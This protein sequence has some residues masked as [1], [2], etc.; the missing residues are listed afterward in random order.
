MI[1]R[2][3]F[4]Q[5]VM[6]LLEQDTYLRVSFVSSK[7]M[8]SK[9]TTRRILNAMVKD[10]ILK[11][12]LKLYS[13][14]AYEYLYS[15]FWH[16]ICFVAN[17]V[18]LSNRKQ[19]LILN[20][21]DNESTTNWL[22]HQISWPALTSRKSRRWLSGMLL[23]ASEILPCICCGCMLTSLSFRRGNIQKIR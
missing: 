12:E 6:Y 4:A 17:E 15:R 22:Y 23:Q 1:N 16:G 21:N 7:L 13:G 9:S 20:R 11:K 10:C 3:L 5:Q 19:T 8:L 18:N 2:K 14:N